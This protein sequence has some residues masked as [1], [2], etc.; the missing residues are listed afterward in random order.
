MSSQYD[1]VNEIIES[2]KRSFVKFKADKEVVNLLTLADR[3]SIDD[4]DDAHEEGLQKG[5][6]KGREEG[7]VLGEIK[8]CFVR[9]KRTA[10]Q[11][12]KELELSESMVTDALK[13]LNL[14]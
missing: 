12:A 2:F 11:I 1:E 13:K 10:Q 14:L 9:L 7:L 3:F 8:Y 5:L 6:Q 4:R